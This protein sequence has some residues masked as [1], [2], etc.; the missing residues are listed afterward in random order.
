MLYFLFLIYIQV[1]WVGPILGG[2]LGGITYEYSQWTG[3]DTPA[4][5]RRFSCPEAVGRIQHEPDNSKEDSV[6]DTQTE[7]TFSVSMAEDPEV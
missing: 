5:Q 4:S 2:I 3:P 1:Y 6:D 7:L